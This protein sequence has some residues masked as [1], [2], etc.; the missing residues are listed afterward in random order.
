MVQLLEINVV[1]HIEMPNLY[2]LSDRKMKHWCFYVS[3]LILKK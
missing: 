3:Q 1:K 2:V